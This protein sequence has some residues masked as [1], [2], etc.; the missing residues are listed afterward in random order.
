MAFYS[1]KLTI[2]FS[3]LVSIFFIIDIFVLNCN[4]YKQ[5]KEGAWFLLLIAS[6]SKR[7]YSFLFCP[8]CRIYLQKTAFVFIRTFCVLGLKTALYHKRK[9]QRITST[10]LL[11]RSSSEIH[12]LQSPHLPSLK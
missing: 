5:I 2:Q 9:H 6:E 11:S 7:L 3:R 4:L 10:S 12:F 1:H 8:H